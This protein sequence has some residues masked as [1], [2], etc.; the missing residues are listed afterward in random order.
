MTE[1]PKIICDP[2]SGWMYGFPREFTFVA[3]GNP[4]T[5][6]AELAEWFVKNGYPKRLVE[7]GMHR[8]CRFWAKDES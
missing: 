2:P 3:T 7:Q 5:H 8:R 1:K 6:D 4:D